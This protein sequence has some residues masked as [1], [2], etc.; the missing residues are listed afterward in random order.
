MAVQLGT[1]AGQIIIIFKGGDPFQTEPLTGPQWG[2]TLFF[3]F[4]TLPIGAGIRLV[5]DSFFLDIARRLEPLSRPATAVIRR[6]KPKI[7]GKADAGEAERLENQS[8]GNYIDDGLDE[9]R[10]LR[11]F[12]WRWR[13]K[14][15]GVGAAMASAGLSLSG[16][17]ED[18]SL[19]LRGRTGTNLTGDTTVTKPDNGEVDLRR[20][21]ELAKNAPGEVP[22]GLEVHP[23]TNKADPVIMKRWDGGGKIPPSQM[24]EIRKFLGGR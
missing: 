10:E 7:T 18:L 11:R 19:R 14:N 6:F 17:N 12:S 24:E 8:S 22:Y 5:P 2:W 23:E 9:E 20:W 15:K 4:L 3:G 21:I 1:I 13:R 16:P